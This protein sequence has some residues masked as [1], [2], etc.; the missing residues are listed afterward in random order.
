[1]RRVSFFALVLLL[2]AGHAVD[3]QSPGALTLGTLAGGEAAPSAITWTF[4][5]VSASLR[6]GALHLEVAPQQR[7]TAQTDALPLQP[8]RLYHLSLKSRR[9]PGTG[10]RVAVNYTGADGKPASRNIVFEL[11]GSPRPNFWPLAPFRQEYVQQFCLPPAA[12]NSSLQ[13]ALAGDPQAGFN[14]VDL[15]ALS[16]TVVT[17]VPFGRNLGPNLLP[18]GDMESVDSAGLPQGWTTWVSTP[19]KMEIVAEDAAGRGPHGGAHYLRIAPGKNFI[20]AARDVPIQQGRAY[21]ISFWTRG[22]ADLGVGMHA[23]ENIHPYPTRVGDPQ[24]ISLRVDSTAWSRHESLWFADSLYAASGQLFIS[25]NPQT[26]FH[27]DDVAIQRIE[28]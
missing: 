20:L 3:A 11:P 18:G 6:E 25:I 13:M 15:Y 17:K 5:G 7:A 23:L 24:P 26:E 10:F 4:Q 1:M 27:L 8:L 28:P 21:R 12:H 16:L 9:G 2:G 14:F 22:K 19:A